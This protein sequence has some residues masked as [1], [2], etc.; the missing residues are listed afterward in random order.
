MLPASLNRLHL[1]NTEMV[2]ESCSPG[3]LED[4]IVGTSHEGRKI[5]AAAGQQYGEVRQGSGEF[6]D[7]GLKMATESLPFLLSRDSLFPLP[8]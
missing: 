1:S 6:R 4:R 2:S 7:G 8:L 3:N 5:L